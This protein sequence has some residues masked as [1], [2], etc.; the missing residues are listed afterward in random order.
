VSDKLL[1]EIYKSPRKE[2]MYLYV[3][4]RQGLEHVPEALLGSFGKPQPLLTM[5]LTADKKLARANTA[6]VMEAIE[7]Q[8]FYFQ[9]PP[10]N[11][12][13]LLTEHLAQ[14]RSR[15]NSPGE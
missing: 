11:E 14:Q 3:N 12:A 7:T 9:M 5:I 15:N 2:E 10:G 4:K 6:E 8:G 13:D 1:C